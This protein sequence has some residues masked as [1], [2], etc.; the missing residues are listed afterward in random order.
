MVPVHQ[1]PWPWSLIYKETRR[2]LEWYGAFER[3][4]ARY[5]NQTPPFSVVN[6]RLRE[7]IYANLLA[8]PPSWEGIIRDGSPIW[9]KTTLTR[10]VG[11]FSPTTHITLHYEDYDLFTSRTNQIRH[12]SIVGVY[13][14]GLSE[15]PSR[16]VY[17]GA[18]ATDLQLVN[19]YPRVSLIQEGGG[20][21]AEMIHQH[22]ADMKACK[23]L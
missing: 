21:T 22:I 18:L 7:D 13:P 16:G 20:I 4:H 8:M 9:I 1:P 5:P 6:I 10:T 11:T 12:I 17:H 14:K 2:Q 23:L 3:L 19:S 15:A